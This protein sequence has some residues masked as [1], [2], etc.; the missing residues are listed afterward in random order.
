[1]AVGPGVDVAFS[2][3]TPIGHMDRVW[4]AGVAYSPKAPECVVGGQTRCEAA[5]RVQQQPFAGMRETQFA[6]VSSELT[7]RKRK[8]IAWTLIQ[9]RARNI[10]QLGRLA[11]VPRGTADVSTPIVAFT[12]RKLPPGPTVQPAVLG[13]HRLCAL[14]GAPHVLDDLSEAAILHKLRA[15]FAQDRVYT[16]ISSIL[17][18]VNP[19]RALPIYSKEVM[20]Q[21]TP[22]TGD[23]VRGYEQRA[24]ET[25]QAPR[26]I[27]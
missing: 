21:Y 13:T 26:P 5:K 17:V 1:M 24:I 11:A 8:N 19:L 6:S 23:I 25:S 15:R 9:R 7:Q 12:P 14:V 18:A 22:T 3:P 20:R 10:Q 4:W 27:H 2:S 16:S